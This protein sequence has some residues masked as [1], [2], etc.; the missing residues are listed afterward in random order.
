MNSKENT[1]NEW[2]SESWLLDEIERNPHLEEKL[3]NLYD[4]FLAIRDIDDDLEEE[5]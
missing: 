2:L 5:M 3:L 4:Y 1:Y